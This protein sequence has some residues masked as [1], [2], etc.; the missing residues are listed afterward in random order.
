LKRVAKQKQWPTAYIHRVEPSGLLVVKFKQKM[1][2]P[3]HPSYIQN[4]TVV[5]DEETY[6]IL[7]F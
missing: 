7:K 3:D 4:E 5:I 6:P 1:K 2:I